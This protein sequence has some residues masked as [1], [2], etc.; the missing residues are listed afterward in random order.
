MVSVSCR[1]G[2]V[3][4]TI[5]RTSTSLLSIITGSIPS[6]PFT[7]LRFKSAA[8]RNRMGYNGFKD[9]E[10]ENG[11]RRHGVYLFGS[12]FV[13]LYALLAIKSLW[14][15]PSTRRVCDVMK[16]ISCS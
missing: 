4:L 16:N 15:P 13:F 1:C 6:S 10:N 8:R 7:N 12:T 9:G 2:W 11:A 3:D 14:F 5:L